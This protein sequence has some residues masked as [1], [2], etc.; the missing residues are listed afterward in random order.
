MEPHQRAGGLSPTSLTTDF[1]FD[2]KTPTL[3]LCQLYMELTIDCRDR[4]SWW[5][6]SQSI[7]KARQHGP[8][9]FKRM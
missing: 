3:P 2:D 8:Q 6:A 4:R 1:D 9:L 5:I 7:D